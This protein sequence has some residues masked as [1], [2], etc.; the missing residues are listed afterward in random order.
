MSVHLIFTRLVRWEESQAI[1]LNTFV[2]PSWHPS[3]LL[4]AS[5]P[6][7]FTRSI[8]GCVHHCNG[9]A[10]A[11]RECSGVGSAQLPVPTCPSP[12]HGLRYTFLPKGTC[13]AQIKASN[14]LLCVPGAFWMPKGRSTQCGNAKPMRSSPPPPQAWRVSTGDTPLPQFP[15]LQNRTHYIK[16]PS[17]VTWSSWERREHKAGRS[18]YNICR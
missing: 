12:A 5:P 8:I 3:Q 13:W 7:F 17:E 18:I 11:R 15:L 6:S 10:A 16:P 9:S 14:P 2:L 4:A 1:C